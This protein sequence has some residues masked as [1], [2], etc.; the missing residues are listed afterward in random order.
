MTAAIDVTLDAV[1]VTVTDD[2]PRILTLAG[3]SG[4]PRIPAGPLDPVHDKTLEQ[5]MRRWIDQLTGVGIGYAEQ[6]YTFGDR[7]RGGR[8]DDS[9]RWLSVA[10]LALVREETPAPGASWVDVYDL[11]PWEDHREGR[12]PVIGEALLPAMKEWAATSDAVVRRE[13]IAVMFGQESGWD[14]IRVL[15]RYELLYEAGL[16][17]EAQ[18]DAGMPV[19]DTVVG[20]TMAYDDRRIAATAL[21]RLRGKLTYRPLVFELLP[22]RFTLTALQRTVEALSGIRL[23]T[24]NFR[25]LVERNRLVEGTGATAATGGRPGELFRFR[26]EVLRER[27]RPGVGVPYR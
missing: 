24:Q 17:A 9:A 10:Y 4:P 12:P 18:I 16:V 23:H 7:K 3:P 21:G 19:A 5:A 20:T 15:E 2:R 6:L 8:R 13:R 14:G 26:P 25:R 1:I 11:F 22:D 27:P